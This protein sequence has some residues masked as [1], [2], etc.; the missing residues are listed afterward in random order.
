MAE[1]LPDV[2]FHDAEVRTLRLDRAG[3]TLEL[4]VAVISPERR[5]VRLTFENVTDVALGDFNDQNVLFDLKV[6][7]ADGLF[8]V[9]PQSSY[10]VGGT[11]RC[12]S[13]R[14]A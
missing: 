7:E 6:V 3:P 5:S 8:D 12:R 10:G 11:F 9:D 4:E 2:S 1:G 13:I 14:E